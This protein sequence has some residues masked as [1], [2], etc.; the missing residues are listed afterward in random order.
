MYVR[1]TGQ[2]LPHS[3]RAL[4]PAAGSLGVW[5]QGQGASLARRH[6]FIQL[7]NSVSS[8]LSSVRRVPWTRA[9][10]PRISGADPCLPRGWGG[11]APH[12]AEEE[13]AWSQGA[14]SVSPTATCCCSL[15]PPCFQH[16]RGSLVRR[17]P[18]PR[19]PSLAGSAIRALGLLSFAKSGP[20]R[21]PP[22]LTS[23]CV[24]VHP[25]LCPLSLC[26]H[27]YFFTVIL[28]GFRGKDI[29]S[30]C[31]A[32]GLVLLPWKLSQGLWTA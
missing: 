11:A 32:K 18:G 3:C 16:P 29:Q 5:P 24:A 14:F 30:A 1:Q 15:L 17:S 6:P 13:G 31:A 20:L 7:P 26:L 8:T 19:C 25:V 2:Q 28:V 9:L 27:F 22:P 4:S 21:R 10:L 23:P 12:L